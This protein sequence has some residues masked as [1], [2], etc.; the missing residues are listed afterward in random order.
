MRI[1][2]TFKKQKKKIQKGGRPGLKLNR[3]YKVN[4]FFVLPFRGIYHYEG[5]LRMVFEH[6][7]RC[8]NLCNVRVEAKP[9]KF[10][11]IKSFVKKKKKARNRFTGKK[12]L[13]PP[14]LLFPTNFSTPSDR[15][16]MCCFRLRIRFLENSR[17][18]S[19]FPNFPGHRRNYR[20]RYLELKFWC[21]YLLKI[22]FCFFFD[23]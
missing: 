9:E 16:R 15:T 4:F 18:N 12:N 21:R 19:I 1:H 3:L 8:W 11:A 5:R 23:L 22:Q 13:H 14:P 6:D 17:S 10:V 7:E 20:F 2:L